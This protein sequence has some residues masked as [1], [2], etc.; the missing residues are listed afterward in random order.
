MFAPHVC[1]AEM[2]LDGSEKPE[3]Q[4]SQ[5]KK[6]VEEN[7]ETSKVFVSILDQKPNG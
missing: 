2:S 5:A 3:Y 6:N 7:N 4:I 1:L